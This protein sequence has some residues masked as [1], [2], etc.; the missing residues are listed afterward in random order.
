[1]QPIKIQVWEYFSKTFGE[2]SYE[3]GYLNLN[4]YYLQLK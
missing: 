2:T 4:Q 1:M 3:V